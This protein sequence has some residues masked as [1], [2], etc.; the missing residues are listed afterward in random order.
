M[1]SQE[2]YTGLWAQHLT[3]KEE[4]RQA[5][6]L[7]N[8]MRQRVADLEDFIRSVA[9]FDDSLLKSADLNAIRATL[10]EWRTDAR[11]LHPDFIN[12]PAY[13]A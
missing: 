11:K 6:E 9:G 10:M 13:K 8:G 12:L 2:A 1:I 3:L 5:D 7:Y 4:K